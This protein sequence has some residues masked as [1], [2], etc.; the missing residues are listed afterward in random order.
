M[1]ED[2]ILSVNDR[3]KVTFFGK[4]NGTVPTV[5][6]V[7]DRIRSLLSEGGEG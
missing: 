6:E 3:S 4:L 2:V 7:Y 5:K 1:V